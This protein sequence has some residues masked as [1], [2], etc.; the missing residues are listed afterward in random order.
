MEI[1]RDTLARDLNK[2]IEEIIQV[3]QIDDQSISS[4]IEEYIITDRIK[5]QYEEILRELADYKSDPHKRIGIWISGF[6]GSG[7]SSFAKNLGYMLAKRSVKGRAVSDLFKEK[8][9]NKRISDLLDYIHQAMPCEIIMFDVSKA[10]EVSGG[11][12]KISEIIYRALLNHLS[13]AQDYNIAELEMD[14]ELEGKL[15]KFVSLSPE[16][17]G[18]EWIQARIGARKLNYASAI[19]Q[20]MDPD[21]FPQADSWLRGVQGKKPTLTVHDVVKRIFD[22]SNRRCHGKAPFF[23]ID[24][25]GQYVAR[26][27]DKIEDLRALVEEMG[28]VGMEQVKARNT[29]GPAWLVVTSQERLEEVVAEIDSKKI[30][31][32][33]LQDRFKMRVDLAPTDIKEVA[34]RRVLGKKRDAEPLILKLYRENQGQLN[35][36]T[37][38]ERTFYY[39]E[40]DEAGFLQ[41]YP[42]LPH[43]IDISIDI[44]SG[45][46][47]QSGALR[48][49]GGS[50]RTI[51]KQA[52][53]LLVNERTALANKPIGSLIT[54]DR[55]FDLVEG[56]LSSEKSK[57]INNIISRFKD[58][59]PA[60]VVKVVCLLEFLKELPRTDVNIAAC[61]VDEVGRPSPLPEVREAIML[62]EKENALHVAQAGWSLPTRDFINWKKKKDG[63]KTPLPEKKQIVRDAIRD[64]FSEPGI[65]KYRY[66]NIKSF[67]LSLSLDGVEKGQAPSGSLKL[68]LF[69]EDDTTDREEMRRKLQEASWQEE[70]KDDFHFLIYLDSRIDDLAAGIY[71]SEKMVSEYNQLKAQG[72]INSE[73]IALL[74]EE[75]REK[76]RQEGLLKQRITEAIGE[77][78]AVFRGVVRDASDLGDGPEAIFKAL[79]E[80]NVPVLYPE[81]KH[82]NISLKGGEAEQLLKA[83]NLNGLSAAFYREDLEEALL[84]REGA[85][86]K[87]NDRAVLLRSLMDYLKERKSYSDSSSLQGRA[88]EEHFRGQGFGADP[89]VVKLGLAL[90]FR[91]GLIEV[92]SGGQRFDSYQE[93]KSREAFTNVKTFR[94]AVFNPVEIPPTPTLVRALKACENLTGE[95]IEA[96]EMVAISSAARSFADKTIA[97]LLPVEAIVAANGLPGKE[98]LGELKGFL[99]TLRKSCSSDSVHLLANEG[100]RLR[101]LVDLLNRIKQHSDEQFVNL[102]RRARIAAGEMAAVLVA[103]GQKDIVEA[104]SAL[105]AL[106]ASEDIYSSQEALRARSEEIEKSYQT[107]YSDLHMRRGEAFVAALKELEESESW[108]KAEEPGRT[109]AIRELSLRACLEAPAAAALAC[110]KC[111]AAVGQMDSDLA[112]LAS[113]TEAAG[114]EL[115]RLAKAIAGTTI[116]TTATTQVDAVERKIQKVALKSFFSEP[117]DSEE[118]VNLA[119]AKLREHLLELV[120]KKVKLM[121]E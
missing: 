108:A 72:K 66:K 34:T 53:E 1:I 14:L 63:I 74:E 25:V 23:V 106:L 8:F 30:E 9:E 28:R 56:N 26:S 100:E 86:Y 79:F 54:L 51:I 98:H 109:Q 94:A 57:D 31:L 113:F 78:T 12:E 69:S 111:G 47:S 121:V 27:K 89:E 80:E 117:I 4:E 95:K 65:S 101:G 5:S 37:R 32:A 97:R 61:L 20:K 42:Y 93:P 2:K 112:A 107:L 39:K 49:Y 84:V 120:R 119:V 43:F 11:D 15:E 60:R 62:L 70:A 58:G 82:F 110:S 19:M 33:K 41:C 38:M 52:Y 48:H 16:V 75:K 7:K 115:A 64:I 36:A 3:D 17:S 77:G 59:W 114:N 46:R 103:R 76:A 118:A 91:A 116:N 35:Q 92:S 85:S 102:V 105:V 6:F 104:R 99:E 29:V 22:L 67:D 73:E 13:Y 18:K 44:M 81:L 96:V 21:T 90:L 87:P 50:N 88:L 71:R 45:L 10:S 68:R 55:I 83:A 40:I 24:E